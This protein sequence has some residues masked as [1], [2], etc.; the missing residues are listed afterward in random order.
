MEHPL[1]Q[2][3]DNSAQN[4]PRPPRRPSH[5]GHEHN[6]HEYTLSGSPPATP[7]GSPATKLPSNPSHSPH[8][9]TS[10]TGLLLQS[11]T[12]S[13]FGIDADDESCDHLNADDGS[14]AQEEGGGGSGRRGGTF[15]LFG[16][17]MRYDSPCAILL[18]L[19]GIGTLGV[20]LGL[21]FP[22]SSSTNEG[23][24]S[25]AAQSR[26]QW[27]IISNILG[28]TYFLS[29]TLSFYPQILTNWKH[30]SK[31]RHGVSLD[32]VVWNIVGF[33]CYAIYTTSFRYSAVVRKEYAERFGGNDNAD[34]DGTGN[35][36][37][38]LARILLAGMSDHSTDES[39][40]Y[41]IEANPF[42]NWTNWTW[43][44]DDDS[45]DASGASNTTNDNS[46]GN[47]DA[48]AVPQVKGNDVAFAWHALILTII[49][50]VQI[51]RAN[52]SEA[53]GR[54][55]AAWVGV[56]T[57]GDAT[58][59]VDDGPHD[60]SI[61][62]DQLTN[63]LLDGGQPDPSYRQRQHKFSRND[64][65]VVPVVLDHER[66]WT[67]R[68]SFT[69]KCLILLLIAMCV[70]GA[71]MV[72]CDVNVGYWGG[73]DQW[74]WLDYLYFLS[75]VKVGVTLVKYVPQVLLNYRRKSTSGW[76]IWNILLDF[77][78]GALSIVQL[79][80]DSLAEARAQGLP[81]SWTGIVGN[82]AKFGLG[83]VSIFFDIIFM[84][85][86]YVLYRNP[87]PRHPLD[88]GGPIADSNLQTPL[89]N[90]Q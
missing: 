6:W 68:I 26:E 74:E 2:I 1:H 63:Q 71:V 45:N 73:G 59:L 70:V 55:S 81:H 34:G 25:D 44:D 88:G 28:Y 57:E 84:I 19:L 36:T 85:Q 53:D 65:A 35:A 64:T 50:F 14:Q 56:E 8:R 21:I 47:G 69:T 49:T 62:P 80:G 24:S 31:A 78:G 51:T 13:S 12:P 79:V 40:G 16:R 33:A 48:V 11:G 20:I 77:S 15:I 66:H 9:Y 43:T 3:A 58:D 23:N 7:T 37:E 87:P 90:E 41:A 61:F 18:G 17:S 42:S 76:Q 89:L 54:N 22:S 29:W 46:S 10:L 27:D 39:A 60:N 32:F 75:F 82:P 67:R 4:S 52:K 72:A 86:H 30:P 5:P 38:A 83:L